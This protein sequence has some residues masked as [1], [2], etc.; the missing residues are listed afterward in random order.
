MG[1]TILTPEQQAARRE[2]SNFIPCDSPYFVSSFPPR[3]GTTL[4]CQYVATHVLVSWD[5]EAAVREDELHA[6]ACGVHR[7]TLERR[8]LGHELPDGWAFIQFDG[9]MR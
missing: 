4:R 5:P 7:K 8:C 9:A 6:Y 2:R 3:V 1:F